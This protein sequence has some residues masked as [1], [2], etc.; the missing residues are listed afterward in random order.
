MT[1]RPLRG[2]SA[3]F[4]TPVKRYSTGMRLRLAFAVA[5]HIE[6]P[7]L[8]VDE[9][10]AVGD[11]AFRERCLGR[12]SEI[13]KHGRTVLFVSHDLGAVTQLCRR[14]L[15]LEAGRPRADGP[16]G[17]VV[18]AYLESDRAGRALRAVFGQDQQGR[19][20]LS[21]V[22]ILDAQHRILTSVRRGDPLRIGFQFELRERHPG[23]N[24][25]IWLTNRE[26][27]KVIEDAYLDWFRGTGWTARHIRHSG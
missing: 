9:V 19:I 3:S 24:L 2:L 20:A 13:G 8:I 4:E 25:G 17:E 6:P 1:S 12:I 26:G 10:L 5:A 16:A 14:A 18:T 23:L 15:W 22:T 27:I 11:A 7:I 21:Q